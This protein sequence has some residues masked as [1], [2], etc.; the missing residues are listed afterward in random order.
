MQKINVQ[1]T[2]AKCLKMSSIKRMLKSNHGYINRGGGGGG[3]GG[4]RRI[5]CQASK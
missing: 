1:Y 5:H 2:S 3:G 4:G